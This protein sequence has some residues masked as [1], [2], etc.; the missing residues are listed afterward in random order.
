MKE[1]PVVLPEDEVRMHEEDRKDL[2]RAKEKN[3]ETTKAAKRALR[4]ARETQEVAEHTLAALDGQTEK[5][6]KLD[7][8]MVDMKEDVKNSESY[9]RYITRACVCCSCFVKDPTIKEEGHWSKEVKKQAAIEKKAKA[10]AKD[11][12]KGKAEVERTF[13]ETGRPDKLKVVGEMVPMKVVGG[14]DLKEIDAEFYVQ[15]KALDEISSIVGNLQG[16]S[17]TMGEEIAKQNVM[18]DELDTKATPLKDRIRDMNTRTRLN[19]I[20]LKKESNSSVI[21]DVGSTLIKTMK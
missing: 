5:I 10:L 2:D 12:G 20:H 8:K 6:N 13:S 11:K 14:E 9:L 16:M 17:K 3:R 21:N 19:K 18:I 15:D 7:G 1:V 4:V